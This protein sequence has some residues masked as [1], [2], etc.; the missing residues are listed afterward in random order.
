M[1]SRR[2][3]ISG[4]SAAS[5]RHSS[6]AVNDV[7]NALS[8]KLTAT[9]HVEPVSPR[10]PSFS[11]DNILHHSKKDKKADEKEREPR[12]DKRLSMVGGKSAKSKDRTAHHSPRVG[13]VKPAKLDLIIES[14][15]LVFYGAS[16]YSSGALF[17]GR[18]KLVVEDPTGLV[19]LNDF[20]MVLRATI[21][22]T[23]P[24][25]KD[26]KNCIERH[27]ELKKWTFISEPTSYT[28][29]KDNQFPFSYLFPGHLPATTSAHIGSLAYALVAEATT[30][31]G[32]KIEF[33]HPL[34]IQRAIPPGP[35]KSSIRIFPPTNLT[36]RVQ[37]P[38]V[39]HPIGTFPVQMTLSGVVEKRADSTTRWRLRKMMWRIE[40]QCKVISSPCPKH[41]H[42][43]SDGK[44]IQHTDVRT[45]G[46][47]EMKNG[48]K[49]DFD[50]TGGEIYLEFEA[51]LATK[52]AHKTSCDVE[53]AAGLDVKHT[54]VIEL[55][56]AEEFCPAKNPHLITPTG[57]ARV[58]R[59]QFALNVT[60]RAGMGISWDEEMPPMY[61]DVPPSPPGYGATTKSEDAFG[62]AIAIMEEY[63]GP[64][65]V[66]HDLE[67]LTSTNADGLPHYREIDPQRINA[68]LPMRARRS[69]TGSTESA[70]SSNRRRLIGFRI[71][72]LEAESAEDAYRRQ[73]LEQ[74]DSAIA[75]EEDY[76]EGVAGQAPA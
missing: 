39:V 76:G 21:G 51:S 33:V 63:D 55:I 67:R 53:S 4:T 29:A 43:V 31:T 62:H 74:N 3:I 68:G 40:E 6:N 70:E 37:V 28:K 45:L 71:D 10:R 25:V 60:E 11:M 30:S 47:D 59:M 13:P 64:T 9:A 38:P 23:K 12:A 75:E 17:S 5:P 58:L 22:T 56:V 42:K 19:K 36:G 44:A 34:K 73:R 66:P 48:W 69:T 27:D 16:S 1:P 46:S 32:E 61:E 7:V 24:I 18:L 2:P 54:L 35:D 65:I 41:A 8:R 50:T 20:T 14:P 49:S 26:C 57:A 52:S 15:P 72:D